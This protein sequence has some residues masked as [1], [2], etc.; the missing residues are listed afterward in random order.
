MTA[1]D[2]K[3]ASPR[4]PSLDAAVAFLAIGD[5]AQA[6]GELQAIPTGGSDPA[7]TPELRHYW[8]GLAC[9]LA[10]A[11]SD[12]AHALRTYLSDGAS[13]WRAGWA[14]LHLGRAYEQAGRMDEASLAY[15]G[16]LAAAG[17]ERAA[18]KLAFDRMSRL[19]NSVPIGYGQAPT[20]PAAG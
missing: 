2:L 6:V 8:L 5:G 18:R 3:V 17:A 9:L 7:L 1:G 4:P 16:C 12:A 13:D 15:R 14:Y 10:F 20:R 19:A 11:W